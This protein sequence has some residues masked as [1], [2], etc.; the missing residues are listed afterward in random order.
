MLPIFFFSP[1]F[2]FVNPGGDVEKRLHEMLYSVG[3][4]CGGISLDERKNRYGNK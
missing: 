2:C 1:V 4:G 3:K